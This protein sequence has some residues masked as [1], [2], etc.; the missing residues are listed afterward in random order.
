MDIFEQLGIDAPD[1]GVMNAMEMY[2][3][4]REVTSQL[5]EIRKKKGLR[6]Q[7]IANELMISRQAVAKIEDP[8]NNPKISTL[9]TYALAVG[10]RIDMSVCEEEYN[11]ASFSSEITQT[12][13]PLS[14]ASDYWHDAEKS[15]TPYNVVVS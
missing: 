6:Q 12:A 4:L 11:F 2:S 5:V 9:I 15:L 14:R 3:Q 7:D 1:M 13:T 8:S 10:A